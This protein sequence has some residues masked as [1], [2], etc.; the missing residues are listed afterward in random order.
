M[1]VRTKER[2]LPLNLTHPHTSEKFGI[3]HAASKIHP[4]RVTSKVAKEQEP[5]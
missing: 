1:Q 2:D 4:P 3:Y 5:Y